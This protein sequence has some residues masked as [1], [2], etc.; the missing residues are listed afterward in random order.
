MNKL[1]LVLLGCL[2]PLAS[3]SSI[4]VEWTHPE[5][6]TVVHYRIHHT[7]NGIEDP[8]Y[9]D[10]L[11]TTNSFPFVPTET[12]EH[13]FW[14]VAVG[15]TDISPPSNKGCA[16]VDDLLRTPNPPVLHLTIK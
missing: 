9:I 11:K 3:H 10:M 2:I 4:L 15:D 16:N 6:E 12:G 13:C 8:T 5:P 1:Y 7:L 14:I